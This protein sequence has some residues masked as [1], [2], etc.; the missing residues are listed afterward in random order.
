MHPTIKRALAAGFFISLWLLGGFSILKSLSLPVPQSDLRTI[1]GLL[2]LVILFTGIMYG[3]RK[4]KT[5]RKEDNFSY[6]RAIKTGILISVIVAI[7]VSLASLLYVTVINP[8]FTNDMVRETE[9][10]LEKSGATPAEMAKKLSRARN[11]FSVTGQFIS[12]LIVQSAAGTL[13]SL[14]LGLFYRTKSTKNKLP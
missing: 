5:D 10:S 3:I 12:G 1:T 8:G 7:I 2:G 14:V 11:E 4:A 9:L 13:F 6:A